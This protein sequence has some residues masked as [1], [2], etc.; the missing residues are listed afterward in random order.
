MASI[1]LFDGVCNFCNGA[2]NFIIKHDT[3]KKFRFA[4]LQ[5]AFGEQM[6]AKFGIG[7]EVDSIILVQRQVQPGANFKMEMGSVFLHSTAALKIAKELGLPWSLA[8]AGIILPTP[9]RDWFYKLFAKYRYALF[10][11][12]DVCMIPTPELRERFIDDA[13]ATPAEARA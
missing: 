10:G 8:F 2:V 6:K 12:K 5:S 7:D 9:I 13:G 4:P 3:D 11:K 1:V